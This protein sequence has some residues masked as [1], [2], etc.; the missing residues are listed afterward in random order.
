M[1][2]FCFACLFILLAVVAGA[3]TQSL[4][5][6]DDFGGSFINPAKWNVFSPCATPTTYDCVREQRDEALRLGLRAYSSNTSDTG[7]SFSD[8]AVQFRNP[9]LINTIQVKTTINSFSSASCPAN[10]EAAHPQFLVSGAYFNTG[11]GTFQDDVQAYVMIER[12][13]DDPSLPQS[14]LRVAAFMSVGTTFFNNVDLGTVQ[15]G[16]EA[17]LTLTWNRASKTFV[18]QIVRQLTT[19]LVE[20]QTMSYS[21]P[22][23]LPPSFLF[24]R[25]QV[26]T[27]V[28][29]CTANVAFAAMK[30]RIEAVSVNAGAF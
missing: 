13:T 26:G 1:R 11:S 27:Y 18:A 9:G 16:E 30:A 7:I 2:Q 19:P 24:R 20:Q 3:Q 17:T 6:Y 28:P 22:D 25:I 8:S 23:S 4:V 14:T 12:R 21:Q 10:P 29:N 15:T 5:I